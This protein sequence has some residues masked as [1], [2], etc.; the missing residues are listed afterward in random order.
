MK[1]FLLLPVLVLALAGCSLDGEEMEDAL[2]LR[3]KLLGAQNV[4]FSAQVTADY[5]DSVEEFT[6]DCTSDPEGTV[7][8]SVSRPEVISGVSGTVSG[9][10]GTLVFD[11]Q[12][13]AFPLMAQDRLPPLSGPWLMMK[14]LRSGY[15]TACVREGE[16]LHI[17]VND[18][19]ADDAF[20]LEVWT[21]GDRVV[22]AEVAWQGRRALSMVLENFETV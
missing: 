7:S 20:T 14:A 9:Q 13:L 11:D 8:F 10:E 21:D 17:T 3:S 6:L 19:Y 12:I 15:I 18:S 5:G 4:R 22:S 1:R 16:L 2:A